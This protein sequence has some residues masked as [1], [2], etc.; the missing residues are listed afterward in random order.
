MGLISAAVSLVSVRGTV[1]IRQTLRT[2]LNWAFAIESP[3][4]SESGL[5]RNVQMD[6][7]HV[8][9]SSGLK[10]TRDEA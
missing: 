10:G 4:G 5:T 9:V 2:D 1:G 7:S 8:G 3:L 6:Y